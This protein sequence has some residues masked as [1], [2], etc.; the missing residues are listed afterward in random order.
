[1]NLFASVLFAVS[2]DSLSQA[3]HVSVLPFAQSPL[4]IYQL[5]LATIAQGV[6]LSHGDG[7]ERQMGWWRIGTD[8]YGYPTQENVSSSI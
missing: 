4:S 6:T 3:L 1:M 8:R 7:L 5:S 2:E